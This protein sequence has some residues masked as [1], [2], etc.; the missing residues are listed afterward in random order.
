MK[1]KIRKSFLK[2]KQTSRSANVKAS[3][4]LLPRFHCVLRIHATEH[5]F[6]AFRIHRRQFAH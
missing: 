2:G 5:F 1:I 6:A 4:Q 3:H